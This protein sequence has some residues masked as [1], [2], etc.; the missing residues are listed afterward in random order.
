MKLARHL[1]TQLVEIYKE[2]GLNQ[3]GPETGG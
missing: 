1:Y 2:N 3:R